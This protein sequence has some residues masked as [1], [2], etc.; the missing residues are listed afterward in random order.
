MTEAVPGPMRRILAID[1]GGLRGLIPA[2]VLAGLEA[3]T[4]RA[5]RETFDFIAGTST[6]A[7]IAAGLVAGVPAGTRLEWSVPLV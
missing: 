1:G 6:G 4:G 5:A 7:V 3:A 2:C